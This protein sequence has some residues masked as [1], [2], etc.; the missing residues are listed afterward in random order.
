VDLDPIAIGF[1]AAWLLVGIGTLL[2]MTYGT[3]ELHGW[4]YLGAVLVILL[5]PLTGIFLIIDWFYVRTKERF[6]I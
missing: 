2:W 1:I 6:R 4:E 5:G 3:A